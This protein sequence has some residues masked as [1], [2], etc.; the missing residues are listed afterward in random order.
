[1]RGS[2]HGGPASPRP[3]VQG[4]R[5]PGFA[6]CAES[7]AR[8]GCPVATAGFRACCS[9]VKSTIL[10][11]QSFPISLGKHRSRNNTLALSPEDL[12]EGTSD[13]YFSNGAKPLETRILTV[14]RAVHRLR[15]L[16]LLATFVLAVSHLA[17]APLRAAD[18]TFVGLLALAVEKDVA[19]QL[20]LSDAT[21]RQ[22]LELIDQREDQALELV[23]QNRDLPPAEQ[24]ARLLPFVN[25]SERLGFALL[26][27]EQ[28]Q[29]LQQVRIARS[30]ML[31]L[32]ES[33]LASSLGL[34][35][36]QQQSVHQLLQQR[37][38]D[39]TRG[40]ESEQRITRAIYE[41][42]LA[43]LLTETQR[44][45]WEKMAGLMPKSNRLP[46]NLQS[47]RPL[48]RSRPS[49]NRRTPSQ[50]WQCPPSP[51]LRSK[52]RLSP[53]RLRLS[54]PSKDRQTPKR[55]TWSQPSL[56]RP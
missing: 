37:T 10:I 6:S 7:V 38:M 3:G 29:K 43:S 17:T 44:A 56:S 52:N 45:A 18:A 8:A 42:K 34:T 22:L 39:L 23:Q 40:G 11:E 36:E 2:W 5:Q 49:P 12:G 32:G 21:K 9:G 51:N 46:A 31:S 15:I 41:R 13:S 28:R 33:D 19:T 48:K 47:P 25:E 50:P 4:N 14:F 16:S 27:L 30:G 54:H 24:A 55:R 26:T 53:N 35:E 1:M 20:G